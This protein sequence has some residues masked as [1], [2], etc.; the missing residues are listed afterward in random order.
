[1]HKGPSMA[2]GQAAEARRFQAE[3]D[4]RTLRRAEEIKSDKT[5]VVAAK[6]IAKSEIKALG[7]IS[8][9]MDRGSSRGR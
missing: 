9:R 2:R 3:D 6:R 4:L 1:M 8:G 7:K 5:R